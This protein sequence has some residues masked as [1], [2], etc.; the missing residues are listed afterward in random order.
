MRLSGVMHKVVAPVVAGFRR[1][2]VMASGFGPEY[3]CEIRWRKLG[4][5]GGFLT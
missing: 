3:D 4:A 1:W 5:A 2:A